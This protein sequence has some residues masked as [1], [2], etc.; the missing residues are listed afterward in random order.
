MEGTVLT[1]SLMP[2]ILPI[3]FQI[4]GPRLLTVFCVGQLIDWP[5]SPGL[6]LPV[7]SILFIS[8]HQVFIEC[9]CEF[10]LV[11][12]NGALEEGVAEGL[13]RVQGCGS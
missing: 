8:I 3:Y 10:S 7:H 9:S 13:G 5:P 4:L 11:P 2:W 1:G 6:L 12:D